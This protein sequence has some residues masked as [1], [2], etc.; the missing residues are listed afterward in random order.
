[1]DA[2]EAINQFV[3]SLS[4]LKNADG[5]CMPLNEGVCLSP[6][7]VQEFYC[8]QNRCREVLSKADARYKPL[9]ARLDSLGQS[10]LRYNAHGDGYCGSRKDIELV[11]IAFSQEWDRVTDEIC[12][13]Q[14]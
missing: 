4:A 2:K 11:Q 8:Q 7:K 5:Q 12:N 13:S 3:R 6:Q 9:L 14:K 1:M 10:F